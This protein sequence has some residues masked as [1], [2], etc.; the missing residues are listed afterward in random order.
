[1]YASWNAR[2]V[3]LVLDARETV[4]IAAKA[5]FAG[6]DLL[7]RDLVESG[8]DPHEVR[9]RMDG[10]GL[11]GG[12]WPLPV[13]WRGPEA[14]FRGDLR[15][16]PRYAEAAAILG[17]SRTGTWVLPEVHPQREAD[18]GYQDCVSRTVQFH[19]DRLGPI[20]DILGEHGSR[21]GLEILGP[22]TARSSRT[23]P[24][25]HRYEHLQERLGSLQKAHSNVGVLVDAFHVFAA[26]EDCEAGLVWGVESVIWVHVADAARSDPASLLDQDRELPGVT[27]WA[28]CR[29]LLKLLSA[30]GYNGPITAEPLGRCESLKGLDALQTACRT[31]LALSSVWPDQVTALTQPN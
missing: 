23:A 5:G 10:L 6:V 14:R 7:V 26:R 22:A 19:L 17:L 16:L 8:L 29:G 28:D 18:A 9:S 4:E 20:A 12:A 2:A 24:F 3:G 25:V 1:M 27:G 11:L 15:V 31:R 30:R 21:L 13:D